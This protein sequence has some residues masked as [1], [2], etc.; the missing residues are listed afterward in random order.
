MQKHITLWH[1]AIDPMVIAVSQ[2]TWDGPT[3][4]DRDIVKKMAVE[5][6]AWQRA[7]T[8]KGLEGSM[9]AVA[10]LGKNGM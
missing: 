7:A 8:R 2:L 3:S 9:E 1:Y 10:E 4:A 6:A 5:I